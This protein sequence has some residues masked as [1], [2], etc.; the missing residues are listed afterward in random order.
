M[1]LRQ[2]RERKIGVVGQDDLGNTQAVAGISE[3]VPAFSHVIGDL[4]MFQLSGAGVETCQR[5][6]I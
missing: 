1:N 4:Q 3:Q 6:D 5:N 2:N